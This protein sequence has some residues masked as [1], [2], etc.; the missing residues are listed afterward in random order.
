MNNYLIASEK[1]SFDVEQS[2]D[3]DS[4][5]ERQGTVVRILE[6]IES[7]RNTEEWSTLKKEIF[8]SRI[9]YLERSMR[10][11]SEKVE[12][13]DSELYRLQGRLFEARKYDLNKLKETYSLELSKIRKL[14][15]P[16]ER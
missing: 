9:E 10:S 14:T 6:A 2:Q 11:E 8:D 3:I 13:K 1:V 7:L 16:T 4:M 15:Q 12:V 5:R